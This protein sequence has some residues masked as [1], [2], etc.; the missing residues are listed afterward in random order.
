MHCYAVDYFLRVVFIPLMLITHFHY[1]SCGNRF[2]FQLIISLSS[3]TDRKF[4]GLWIQLS[5]SVI[6]VLVF[7]EL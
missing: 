4:R 7:D 5:F 1:K 3:I 2:P 6:G